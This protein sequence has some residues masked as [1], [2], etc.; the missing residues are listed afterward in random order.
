MRTCEQHR[1]VVVVYETYSCPLCDTED[2]RDEASKKLNNAESEIDDLK[3]KVDS[4]KDELQDAEIR[5][6][7][8]AYCDRR[9]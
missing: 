9:D 8:G 7:G 3:E 4:L 5:L 6:S 1:E 2:E